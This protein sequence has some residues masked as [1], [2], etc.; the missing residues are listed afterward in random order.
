MPRRF[1]RLTGVAAILACSAI[2]GFELLLWQPSKP[3]LQSGSAKVADNQEP[4]YGAI[5]K[6]LHQTFE[7]RKVFNEY[8][9]YIER[10]LKLNPDWEYYLWTDEDI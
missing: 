8:R 4:R 9:K 10:C 3:R 1:L 2:I 5:P 6:I 7:T